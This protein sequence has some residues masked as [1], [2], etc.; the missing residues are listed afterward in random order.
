MLPGDGYSDKEIMKRFSLYYSGDE[1]EREFAPGQIPYFREKWASLSE[2]VKEIKQRFTRYYNRKNNRKGFFWGD[3]FKSIIVQNGETLV[4][5]LA[6][7]DLNPVRAG[8]VKKPEEYRWCALGHHIQTGNEDDFFSSDFGF[9]GFET[10]DLKERIRRY[11]EY[12]YEAGAL[13]MGKGRVIPENVVNRERE[14]GYQIT[15]SDRFLSKTRYFTDSG[16]IG[17]RKFVIEHFDKFKDYLKIKNDRKPKLIKG[18]DGIY[19]MRR[20]GD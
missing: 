10:D 2:F 3:R 8:I 13:D 11:R 12:V 17:S 6:Y 19:S 4:N 5:C 14:K 7:L 16:I 15:R 18:L 1:E 20:L 9:E